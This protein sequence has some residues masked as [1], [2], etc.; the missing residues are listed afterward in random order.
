MNEPQTAASAATEPESGNVSLA[1]ATDPTTIRESLEGKSLTALRK[2]ASDLNIEGRSKLDEDG[3]KSAI[4]DA[5]AANLDAVKPGT[6]A[7]T[8]RPP[9]L[10][11]AQ[12]RAEARK[13][14]RVMPGTDGP[15]GGGDTDNTDQEG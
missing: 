6:Q 7:E 12:G 1:A 15:D 2:E 8:G 11:V 3:L 4:V 14:A 10:E 9:A 5:R 13:S